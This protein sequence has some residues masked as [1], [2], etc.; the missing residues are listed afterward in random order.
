MLCKACGTEIPKKAKKC[1]GCGWQVRREE[2]NIRPIAIAGAV[3]SFVGGMFPFIQ[4]SDYDKLTPA[5]KYDA[6]LGYKVVDYYNSFG[7]MTMS[8]SGYGIYLWHFLQ[9]PLSSVRLI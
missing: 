3:I 7:M 5:M 2:R 4:N 6:A 1:P 8:I 9:R